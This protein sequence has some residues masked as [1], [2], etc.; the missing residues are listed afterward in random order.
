MKRFIVIL[1]IFVAGCG[2]STTNGPQTMRD[3]RCGDATSFRVIIIRQ[4]GVIARG[5]GC[6]RAQGWCEKRAFFPTT[7]DVKYEIGDRIDVPDDKCFIYLNPHEKVYHTF[8]AKEREGRT[9]SGTGMYL[10]VMTYSDA[11]VTLSEFNTYSQ[12]LLDEEK[13]I[14]EGR[15]KNKEYIKNMKASIGI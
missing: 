10:P 8:W 2:G 11:N 4:D 3:P 1:S 13:R 5:N 14:E 15:A 12:Q 7:D 6:L 9:R